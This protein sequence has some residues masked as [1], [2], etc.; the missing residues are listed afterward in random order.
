MLLIGN[1]THTQVT[2]GN[3][4]NGKN[5]MFATHVERG[6]GKGGR[7]GVWDNEGYTGELHM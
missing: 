1:R 3:R 7:L 4:V 5:V 6:R 2:S